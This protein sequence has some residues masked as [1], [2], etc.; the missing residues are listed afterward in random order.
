MIPGI[1]NSFKVSDTLWRGARPTLP[2]ILA[3]ADMGIRTVIDLE[4]WLDWPWVIWSSNPFEARSVAAAGMVYVNIPCNPAH[5]E[6]EDVAR[7]LGLVRA[8]LNQPCFVHCRQGADR[9]GLMCAAYRIV[10]EGRSEESAIAELYQFGYHADLYPEIL[11]Y[12]EA[13]DFTKFQ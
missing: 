5:P 4:A 7:F 9:T 11:K 13:T 2:G 10:V 12:I 6:D 1:P 8:P 3:L